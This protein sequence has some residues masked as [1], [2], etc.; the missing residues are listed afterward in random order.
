M[1][2]SAIQDM[3]AARM[4]GSGTGYTGWNPQW[5]YDRCMAIAPPPYYP[6]TGRYIKNRYYEIDP[7][8]FN[9]TQWF[10]DNQTGI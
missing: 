2:G 4:S 3:N 5:S 10:T 1:F 7:V 9:V 6:T 8:G